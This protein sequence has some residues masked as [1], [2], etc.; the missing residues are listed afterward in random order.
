MRK[1]LSSLSAVGV[2]A[3]ASLVITTGFRALDREQAPAEATPPQVLYSCQVP[4]DVTFTNPDGFG[5][6]RDFDV[7]SWNTFLAL[8][9]PATTA[10]LG[11]APCNLQNGVARDCNKELP[12]GDYGPTVWETYK[13]DWAVFR[14]SAAG[15]IAP[16]GWNCPLDPLPGCDSVEAMDAAQAR[17]PV[18]RM[19]IK[20]ANTAQEFLQAGTFAPLID[21][22]GSFIR[23]EMRMNEDEFHTIDAAKL[24]DSNNQT[25]DINLQPV[26]SNA[27]KT[28]GPMEVKAA[29]KILTPTDDASRFH[30]RAVEIAWPN[31]ARKNKYLCKQ[32]T[33]GLIGLHIAHKTQRAPQW[34]WSTFEQVDNYRGLHPSLADPNCPAS[35]CPPN[36]TPKKSDGTPWN[37]D[38][39]FRE[40]P[41]VQVVVNESS[42]AAVR[43]DAKIVND[44]VRQKLAAL[45]SV[46]QY[47]ELVSTQWPSAPYKKDGKPGKVNKKNTLID[48]GV[49]QFPMILANSSMETYLMGPEEKRNT[50]SC[51][52]CHSLAQIADP[53]LDPD[54]DA[55]HSSD[56]SYLLSEAYPASA[57]PEE[58]AH[59]RALLSK[60]FDRNTATGGRPTKSIRK[61]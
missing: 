31:P 21:Q 18:L 17:L 49:N 6:Q 25:G 12:Q 39:R 32:Y 59:R 38:P 53:D 2:L 28:I 33:M 10:T 55:D 52:Y 15:A 46:W 34:I 5:V 47:Y 27:T 35:K 20:D 19:I 4:Y 22:N 43:R 30:T 29:W 58:T 54:P 41:S 60:M 13:P 50:S 7:Y 16:A 23:Y 51:M 44:E 1:P 37:G 40:T 3:L 14:G 45:G 9:W 36:V 56:F 24:W 11:T 8:N 48:Q 26:G 42:A 57:K 61:Q